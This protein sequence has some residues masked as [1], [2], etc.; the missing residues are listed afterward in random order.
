MAF[1]RPDRL[2]NA[3]ADHRRAMVAIRVDEGAEGAL[4]AHVT[5]GFTIGFATLSSISGKFFGQTRPRI[6]VAWL[7]RVPPLP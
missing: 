2:K 4:R 6:T 7:E 3:N 1:R 5:I